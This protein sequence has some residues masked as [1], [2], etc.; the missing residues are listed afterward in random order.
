[1][2]YLDTGCLLKL[3]Y[4][5]PESPRVIELVTGKAITL[6]PLHDVELTNALALKVFRREA[7]SS[8]VKAISEGLAADVR[9]GALY[10]PELSWDAVLRDAKELAS[11]YTAKFGTRSLDILHCAAA[12]LLQVSEFVTTDDRQR[13]LAVAIGLVCPRL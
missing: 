3:Y 12:R 13:K 6:L 5:E 4:P 11:T 1:M 9:S 8:Q 10:R 2:I 7:R